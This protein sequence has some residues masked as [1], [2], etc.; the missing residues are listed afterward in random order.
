MRFTAHALAMTVA[1]TMMSVSQPA[2]ADL[3]LLDQFAAGQGQLASAGFD[4]TTGNVWIYGSFDPTVRGYTPAGS[5]LS[6]VPR[7]GEN[8]NDVD[9][10]FA[11]E[12]LT[13]GATA[14]PAGS[15]LF[16]NGESGFADIYAVDKTSG[17]ILA[18]LNTSFGGSHVVGG[19]YHPRRNTFFLVQ[20]NVPD[21]ANENRIAAIDPLTGSVLNSFQ[22]TS[23]FSVSFGDLEVSA[24]TGNL[25]VVSS[26]EPRVG[27]FT[28]TG[29]FVQYLAL[30]AG[31]SGL[32][33]IGLNDAAGE[34]WV[35]NTSGNVFHLGGFPAVPSLAIAAT[36]AN[37]NEGHSGTTAFTFTVTRSG[38]LIGTTTV[39]YAVIGV[40]AS[41][42]AAS[43]FVGNVFPGGSVTFTAGQTSEVIS[44]PVLG[45][46]I[47]EANENF[48]VTLS[49]PT[50]GATIT[51][52]VATG[53]IRNDDRS[54]AIAAT[55]ANMNE[56][57][58]GATALTFTVTRSGLLTGTTTVDFA[59]AGNG[60]NPAAASDFQNG[61][62]LT[63]TVTFT[64]GQ[65]SKVI[66]ILV[67]GDLTVELNEGFRVT[68][69]NPSLG[70]VIALPRAAA[71]L[72]R[73]DDI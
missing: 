17:T 52:A 71:G 63:G 1:A 15:L 34:A 33:G 26:V 61:V 19:A 65:T 29:G 27:E 6:S 72:I 38:S 39:N 21:T 43:D 42:A 28:P 68:L 8:A 64:A 22:I 24:A 30:P 3:I 66:T 51:T 25:L 9:L 58:A 40:G 7:P 50:G 23:K 14:I 4:H 11:P 70:A 54:L 56:G 55:S 49:N 31:V 20:D 60:V 16:I 10:E 41:P 67:S 12:S 46:A 62:F 59:V 57:N 45:N 35:T 44:I 32:S 69:L 2:D 13:L 37:K 36:S 73:N 53:V 47:V 18:T 5:F 48:R